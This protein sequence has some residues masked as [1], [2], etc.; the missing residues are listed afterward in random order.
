MY[1]ANRRPT[2]LADD[3]LIT[4]DR[5]VTYPLVSNGLP[6]N[7]DGIS[8]MLNVICCW[9]TTAVAKWY[10]GITPAMQ[11]LLLLFF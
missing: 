9:M 11:K 4:I 7:Y 3:A 10:Q 8:L 6:P 2:I 1:G 5:L